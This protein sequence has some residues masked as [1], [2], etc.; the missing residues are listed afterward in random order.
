MTN[1]SEIESAHFI[2]TKRKRKWETFI[3]KKKSR[4]FE[5]SKTICVTFLFTKIQT[6]YVMRFFMKILK[7]AFVYKKHD[8]L[9]YVTLLYTQKSRHFVKSKT[10]CVTFLYTVRMISTARFSVHTSEEPV[11]ITILSE[12]STKI[13]KT[14]TQLEGLY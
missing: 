11:G 3:Y 2:Y 7:L 10:I 14:T 6:L 13:L 4:H 9:R 12:F 1:I 5:K 8:T